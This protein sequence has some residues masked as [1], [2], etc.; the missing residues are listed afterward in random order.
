M[1]ADKPLQDVFNTIR[2]PVTDAVIYTDATQ[3][4]GYVGGNGTDN[5]LYWNCYPNFF[6]DRSQNQYSSQFDTMSCKR[7]GS[8]SLQN[9]ANGTIPTANVTTSA[10][11]IVITSLDDV[12]VQALWDNTTS[13]WRIVQYRPSAN[14][15]VQIGTIAGGAKTDTIYLYEAIVANVPTL[16]VSYQ[17][18]AETASVGA[19]A[20]SAGGVFTAASLTVIADADFPGNIANV[21]TRGNFVQMDGYSFMMSKE[22]G[23]YN[24]DLNSI[25]SWNALGVVQANSSPDQ[26]VGLVKYKNYL[27]AFGEDSIQFF[28]NVGNSAPKSPLGRTDQA[29]MNWGCPFAKSILVMDDAVYWWSKSSGGRWGLWKIDGGFAATKLST[30]KE[31]ALAQRQPKVPELYAFMDHGKQHII[32]TINVQGNLLWNCGLSGDTGIGGSPAGQPAAIGFTNDPFVLLP[33]DLNSGWLCWDIATGNSWVW[34]SVSISLTAFPLTAQN[35]QNSLSYQ[36][37]TSVAVVWSSAAPR[38]DIGLASLSNLVCQLVSDYSGG[39]YFTDTGLSGTFKYV[40]AAM[41]FNWWDF[42][43]NKLKRIHRFSV[44]AKT[45]TQS[46]GNPTLA[47][48]TW[49]ISNKYKGS[50]V[51]QGTT[52]NTY[53]ISKRV[54]IQSQ[55][56]DRTSVNN[57]GASRN[58]SFAIIQKSDG[59]WYVRAVELD[60][61]QGTR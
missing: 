48:Y 58:W 22:G 35:F 9:I 20:T 2:I 16:L 19:Y 29:Q 57:L 21:H 15:S 61:S 23:V 45:I 46:I 37:T 40:T 44:I 51:N 26:G 6:T 13:L 5:G 38:T 41:Q 4:Y 3:D 33:T 18:T 36:S 7:A 34:S 50:M 43:N 1:S 55:L 56:V 59:P 42:G 47:P 31:D 17:N 25:T 12:F 49:V 52:V 8:F 14:T 27:M 39:T 24:S 54:C 60:I 11:N 53:R 30:S 32:T 10:C 28:N